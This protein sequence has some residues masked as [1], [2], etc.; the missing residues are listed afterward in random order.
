MSVVALDETQRRIAH[1]AASVL[2]DYPGEDLERYGAVRDAVGLLPAPVGEPF[3]T[4]LDVAEQWGARRLSEHYIETFDR[5][6]RCTLY[7]SYYDAGDTRNRGSA[8]LAYREA[9]VATGWELDRRELP[10]FLP[11]VLELA[12]RAEGEI[13]VDLLAAHRDGL[14]V[15]RG[16][17]HQLD[18]P[19]AHVLDALCLTL[20]PLDAATHERVLS[21]ITQG[22]PAELVG[23]A[24][25][26]FPQ[27]GAAKEARP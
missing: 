24:S 4:F 27:Y 13:A 3:V 7:L 10:D 12:A 23:I 18:S 25:L 11:V 2:L 5:R 26:P 19:Y 21:L 6:R 17:L 14:E 15:L 16:A 8:I 9:L 22:P 1:M 20:L